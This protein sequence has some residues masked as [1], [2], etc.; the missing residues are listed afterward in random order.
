MTKPVFNVPMW[1]G[2][3]REIA[4]VWRLSKRA[5]FA[6]CRLWTHPMRAEIR[7]EAAGEFVRSEAGRDPIALVDL[8]MTWKAQFQEKGWE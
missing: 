8:A 5:S 4:H 1:D 2:Q 6:E 3:A 7:V